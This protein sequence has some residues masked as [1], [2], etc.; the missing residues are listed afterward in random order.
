MLFNEPKL[1]KSSYQQR[2]VTDGLC[3]SALQRAEIAEISTSQPGTD[4]IRRF[5]ALQRAEIAEIRSDVLRLPD[6]GGVSV[7][8]NEPKLLKFIRSAKGTGK[9][10]V[11]VLFNE[12]K[13]LKY[14][15]AQPETPPASA[16]SV[17]FNEPKLL[18]YRCV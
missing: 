17:L 10:Q 8:F 13:L 1:L 12:P 16:V 5:S 2:I 9:T 6:G 11:S 18:K 14:T 4:E 15:A 7:L 3:F